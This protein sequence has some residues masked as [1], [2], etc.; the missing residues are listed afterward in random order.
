MHADMCQKFI[1]IHFGQT[2]PGPMSNELLDARFSGG[3]AIDE[4]KVLNNED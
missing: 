4:S 3:K 2:T 1:S